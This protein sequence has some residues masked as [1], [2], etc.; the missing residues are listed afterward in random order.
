MSEI[1]WNFYI[2]LIACVGE[3]SMFEMSYELTHLGS[4]F[5]LF[6][7]VFIVCHI[8][9]SVIFILFSHIIYILYYFSHHL[10]IKTDMI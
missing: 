8:N 3:I 1:T 2:I 9:I 10:Y 5:E 7:S 6:F 4:F